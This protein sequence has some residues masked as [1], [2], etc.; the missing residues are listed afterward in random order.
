MCSR[1]LKLMFTKKKFG[2]IGIV[3][4]VQKHLSTVGSSLLSRRNVAASTA[5]D[6]A[7]GVTLAGVLG[8]T[9]IDCAALDGSLQAINTTS[10]LLIV[11]QL[12]RR[13]ALDGFTQSSVDVLGCSAVDGVLSRNGAG[14][15]G[16]VVGLE[17]AVELLVRYTRQWEG[18]SLPLG[19]S[20]ASRECLSGVGVCG[21]VDVAGSHF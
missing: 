9:S 19:G 4:I 7:L 16:I 14:G 20:G 2:D 13:L 11:S 5:D 18:R 6:I 10:T 21:C 17:C 8:K 15:I 12:C 3:S 1:M